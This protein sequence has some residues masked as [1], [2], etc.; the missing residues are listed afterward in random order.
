[1]EIRRIRASNGRRV[2]ANIGLQLCEK[3]ILEDCKIYSPFHRREKRHEAFG[4]LIK[5]VM[6]GRA[7][8]RFPSLV[9]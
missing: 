1:M 3:L 9:P 5:G 4:E 6:A 8:R 7:N 2:A